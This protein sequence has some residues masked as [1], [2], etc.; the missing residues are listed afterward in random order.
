MTSFDLN[1]FALTWMLLITQQKKVCSGLLKDGVRQER[2]K[3]KR[4]Y[5]NGVP[6]DQVLSNKPPNTSQQTGQNLWRSGIILNTRY[7]RLDV[8]LVLT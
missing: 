3:L 5:F 8:T 2:Y 7:H 4:D 1:R 6:E